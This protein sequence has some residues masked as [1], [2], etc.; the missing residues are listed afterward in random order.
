MLT[1]DV[2]GEIEFQNKENSSDCFC[3]K[4]TAGKS[5]FSTLAIEKLMATG[6]YNVKLKSSPMGDDEIK[7]SETIRKFLQGGLK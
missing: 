3:L 6:K 7:H 5:R 2:I 4:L 1:A